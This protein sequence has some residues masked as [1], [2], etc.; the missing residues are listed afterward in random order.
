MQKPILCQELLCL[1]SMVGVFSFGYEFKSPLSSVFL[2]AVQ[3]SGH[4]VPVTLTGPPYILLQAS[5]LQDDTTV[6][7]VW[8]PWTG[9]REF[10]PAWTEIDA[11]SRFSSQT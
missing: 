6:C 3:I 1:C 9:I 4:L 7:Q 11:R 8:Q 5:I 2:H 10:I